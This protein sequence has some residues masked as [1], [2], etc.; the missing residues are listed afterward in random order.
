MIFGIQTQFIVFMFSFIA[1]Q[2]ENL[3]RSI[4]IHLNSRVA[5]LNP[6]RVFDSTFTTI[7]AFR[8]HI[9][10][11]LFTRFSVLEPPGLG[12]EKIK[13][14]QIRQAKDFIKVERSKGMKGVERERQA[15]WKLVGG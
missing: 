15:E 8:N 2:N 10:N 5:K 9:D 3:C 11:K 4:C 6:A 13:R 7:C 14:A 1:L 12:N